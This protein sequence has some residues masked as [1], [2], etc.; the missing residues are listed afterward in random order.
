MTSTRFRRA[1]ALGVIAAAVAWAVAWGFIGE[2]RDGSVAVLGL[3]EGE[4]HAILTPALAA[5]LAAV[6]AWAAVRRGPAGAMMVVGIGAMLAGNVLAFGL[7][8]QGTPVADGGAVI[9]LA[10]AAL[11]TIAPGVMI[12]ASIARVTGRRL[13]GMA[14]ASAAIP[15]LAVTALAVPA[16]ASLALFPLVDALLQ[17]LPAADGVPAVPALATA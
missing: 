16:A 9:F 8:G 13:L 2:T 11:A 5:V 15:L 14:L 6:I 17:P 4:W 10:G 12:G 7:V 3:A 1:L